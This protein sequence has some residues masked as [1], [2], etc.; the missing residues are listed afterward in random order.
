MRR[1]LV[2]AVLL[3]SLAIAPTA[4]RA[5]G[6]PASDVL[7]LQD[8]YL[9]YT[10]EVPKPLDKALSDLLKQTKAKGYPLKVAIIASSSDLGSVPQYFGTP[11][12]YAQF[13][14]SEIAFNKPKPLLVVMP[15]GYGTAKAGASAQAAVEALDKPKAGSGDALGRAAIKGVVAL[16][17]AAGKPV[18]EPKLPEAAGS[19]GGTSPAIIFGVPV[20]LLALGALLATVRARRSEDAERKKETAAP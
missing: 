8:A 11:Q 12:P 2:T 9:P 1:A 20:A 14:E 18:P 6:D 3:A 17:K 10:P 19:G 15:S 7:L 16:A 5:D 4:A 13:L